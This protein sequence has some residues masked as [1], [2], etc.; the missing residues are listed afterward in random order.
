MNEK[1]YSN[2]LADP[3]FLK[4]G[5]FKRIATLRGNNREIKLCSIVSRYNDSN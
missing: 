3:V 2:M 5:N 4:S 1:I